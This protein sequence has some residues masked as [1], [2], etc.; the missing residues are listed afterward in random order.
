METDMVVSCMRASV[1]R[2]GRVLVVTLGLALA[3]GLA[4]AT[5]SAARAR[6]SAPGPTSLSLAV[7]TT[8]AEAKELMPEMA[9]VGMVVCV[10]LKDAEVAALPK[11]WLV[12]DG[13]E[14]SAK[15]YPELVARMAD[16]DPKHKDAKSFKLPNAA[17]LTFT[18]PHV[19]G[20]N[21]ATAGQLHLGGVDK[22]FGLDPKRYEERPMRWLVRAK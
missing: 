18:I 21:D 13:R 7:A 16:A 11:N 6:A 22:K 17:G 1:R 12:C 20:M 19:E 15:D 9:V 10:A 14:V 4:A 8:V 5:A 3:C 2:S